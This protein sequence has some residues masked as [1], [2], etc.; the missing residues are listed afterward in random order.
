MQASSVTTPDGL[1][2]AVQ[3]WGNPRGAE[4]L[5]IHGFNQSHLSWQRQVEDPALAADFRMIT[6]DLRGHGS[7]DK[8]LDKARYAHDRWGDDVAAIMR[9]CGLRR[10]VIAGWSLGGNV[11]CD[12]VRSF[13]TQNLAG[14]NFVSAATKSEHQFFGPGRINY[15]KMFSEDLATNIAATRAFLRA[16]FERQP[17]ED[18]FETMLAFNMVVPPPVRAGV[19][20]RPPNAGDALPEIRCPVLVTH[21]DA[22]RILLV[23][24]GKFT[25]AAVKGAKLSLYAGVGHA[26]FWEDTPRFNRELAEFVRAANSIKS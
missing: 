9:A 24:L 25:A 14:I 4:I 11:I 1:N 12:Y 10:P 22:D 20:G 3:E 17:T 8:P 2:L 23:G 19:L 18:E 6:F 26:P 16:C 7:S 21:G 5:F 15:P 13:G